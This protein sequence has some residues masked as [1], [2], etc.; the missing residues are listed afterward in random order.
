MAMRLLRQQQSME[1]FPLI[2]GVSWPQRNYVKKCQKPI[3]LD[4]CSFNGCP[5]HLYGYQEA[6]IRK[7]DN[8]K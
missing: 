6:E 7:R 3:T 4:Q 5:Y 2:S 1:G 8:A